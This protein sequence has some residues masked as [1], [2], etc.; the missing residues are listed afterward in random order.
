MGLVHTCLWA[1]G[2]QDNR[3]SYMFK[4]I[5]Q[6]IRMTHGETY[7]CTNC[8]HILDWVTT[9]YRFESENDSTRDSAAY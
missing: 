7:Q 9:R 6:S 3:I 4:H 2:F 1:L 5:L 8:T